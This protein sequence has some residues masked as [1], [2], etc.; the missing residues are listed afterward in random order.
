LRQDLLVLCVTH[1][2]H[3]DEGRIEIDGDADGTLEIWSGTELPPVAEG[4]TDLEF[5][6]GLGLRSDDDP[7]ARDGGTAPVWDAAPRPARG[8]T[9]AIDETGQRLLQ[10]MGRR[11]GWTV[12]DLVFQTGLHVSQVIAS[13]L[14]L[15]LSG[16]VRDRDGFFDPI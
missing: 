8:N 14:L 13:L 10:C 15:T 1:Q 16:H 2:R 6:A 7:P 12:G 9:D 4:D 5:E 11:C 3:L